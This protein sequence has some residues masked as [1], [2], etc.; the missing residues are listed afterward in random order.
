LLRALT[1]KAGLDYREIVGAYAR[2]RTKI[3]N[4][5]LEVRR[6]GPY[7]HFWCGNNP[8]FEVVLVDENGKPC[9]PTLL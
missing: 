1:A 8:H 3:A 2:R 9:R 5:L 4:D 7:Q 6:D